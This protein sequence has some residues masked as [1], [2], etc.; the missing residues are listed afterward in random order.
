MSRQRGSYFAYLHH[1]F[2]YI[3]TGF[4]LPQSGPLKTDVDSTVMS[5]GMLREPACI[6][7]AMCIVVLVVV[8]STKVACTVPVASMFPVH[9]TVA[10]MP[11]GFV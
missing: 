3:V 4:T 5:T 10:V 1:Q 11:S 6:V 2:V 7:P 9:F 8:E